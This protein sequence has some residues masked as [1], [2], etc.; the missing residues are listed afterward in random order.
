MLDYTRKRGAVYHGGGQNTDPRSTTANFFAPYL[1]GVPIDAAPLNHAEYSLADRAALVGL[2]ATLLAVVLFAAIG[3]VIEGMIARYSAAPALVIV[4][5]PRELGWLLFAAALPIL[6]YVVWVTAVPIGSRS[7]GPGV[8]N[9]ALVAEYLIVTAAVA[10]MG[11]FSAARIVCRHLTAIG[12]VTITF[13]SLGPAAVVLLPAL[14]VVAAAGAWAFSFSVADQVM[15]GAIILLSV[16]LLLALRLRPTTPPSDAALNLRVTGSMLRSLAVTAALL[17]FVISLL[18]GAGLRY[19][20]ASAVH[21][22]QADPVLSQVNVELDPQVRALRQ[23]LVER[24][25]F[26]ADQFAAAA[27]S[28]N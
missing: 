18:G 8:R 27:Q 1:N 14:A 6:M 2:I 13:G 22:I 21:R 7:A 4:P 10:A 9:V 3:A 25:R 26:E 5:R 17:A 16:A 24:A 19:V 23:E 15:T 28:A 12:G 20:E 11:M